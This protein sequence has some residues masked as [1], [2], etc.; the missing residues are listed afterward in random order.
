M[1]VTILFVAAVL[2]VVA[3]MTMSVG[4]Q[5]LNCD[6]TDGTVLVANPW[7]DMTSAEPWDDYEALCAQ[8]NYDATS[9]TTIVHLDPPYMGLFPKI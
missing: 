9:T 5:Q 8:A 6:T 4:A 7:T 1:R 3:I 2:W